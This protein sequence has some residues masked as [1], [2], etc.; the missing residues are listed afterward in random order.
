MTSISTPSP[1]DWNATDFIRE[2]FK[3]P[4]ERDKQYKVGASNLSNPCNR[5]L[6]EQLLGGQMSSNSESPWWFGAVEGTALHLYAETRGQDIPGWIPES[7]VVLGE[8]PGYGVIKS[9]SDG[10]YVPTGTVV[11]LKSTMREKLKYI[12]RAVYDE[13]N[14]YEVTK[15]TEARLKVNTYRDQTFLYGLG[16]ENAGR[17]VNNVALVFICR[18]GTGDGDFWGHTF[19]YDRERALLVLDRGARLWAWLEQGH[20]PDELKS[21]PG[22]YNCNQRRMED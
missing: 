16:Q 8:F 9:T 20:K 18:D 13:P 15:V 11:D 22:C 1:S 6:A 2:L 3:A 21:H 10:F 7:K 5:C 19:P 4:T 17:T 14:E 12:K